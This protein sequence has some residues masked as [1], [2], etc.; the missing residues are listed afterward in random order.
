MTEALNVMETPDKLV[1][2]MNFKR[3]TR[4]MQLNPG[5]TVTEYMDLFWEFIGWNFARIFSNLKWQ[6]E[7]LVNKCNRIKLRVSVANVRT[8]SIPVIALDT[9]KNYY[10]VVRNRE[11]GKEL[12]MDFKDNNVLYV[13]P[14]LLVMQNPWIAENSTCPPMVCI[15]VKSW[16]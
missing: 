3:T 9:L 13:S 8:I 7:I 6:K 4:E 14:F 12:G 2:M 1:R 16:E 11:W 5:I 10:H 15:R